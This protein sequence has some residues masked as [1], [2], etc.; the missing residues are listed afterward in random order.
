MSTASIRSVVLL[1]AAA[2]ACRGGADRASNGARI[3][4]LETKVQALASQLE[5]DQTAAAAKSA[6]NLA[7]KAA[8]DIECPAPWQTL[9]PT[10]DAVWACRAS[11]PSAGGLWPN[12]NVTM[13]PTEPDISP[14][15]YFEESL[16][17]VPQLRAARRL[18]GRATAL[19]VA[20][21]Y[22]AVYEHDLLGKPLRV[23]ATIGVLSDRVYGVS[24]SAA[25]PAF[26]DNEAQFRRITSSFRIKP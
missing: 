6:A 11:E 10:G 22:E 21:A 26:A 19:G 12:C 2:S 17:S 15:A 20:P 24:C 4:A 7:A 9:G 8:F 14:Q 3:E 23:L 1:V 13:G 25:P 18:S 5:A 16:A